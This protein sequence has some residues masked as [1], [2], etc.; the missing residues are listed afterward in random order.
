[1][2]TNLKTDPDSTTG[3]AA[4]TKDGVYELSVRDNG[5][6]LA[7][8]QTGKIFSLF[9]RAHDH[10]EG[11]GIGLYLVKRILDNS[12]EGITVVSQEGVGSEFIV[13]F[14]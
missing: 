12:G 8:S 10:V 4:I 6:G 3:I 1:M 2:D 9:K 14:K 5:L 13:R 11:S 7:P